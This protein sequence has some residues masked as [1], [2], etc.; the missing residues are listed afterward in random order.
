MSFYTECYVL[1]EEK[2]RIM[3]YNKM[4]KKHQANNIYIYIYLIF[5]LQNV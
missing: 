2:M 5:F 4:N 1:T 3:K